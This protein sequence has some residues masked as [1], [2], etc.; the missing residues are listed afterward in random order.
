MA[1]SLLWGRY[2]NRS[3]KFL[4][5]FVREQNLLTVSG[6]T[7]KEPGS[8]ERC[9]RTRVCE[10][11][12]V[13]TAGM[14][15]RMWLLTSHSVSFTKICWRRF[16]FPSGL[17]I[18]TFCLSSCTVTLSFKSIHLW[19]FPICVP[20]AGVSKP[21]DIIQIIWVALEIQISRN[22]PEQSHQDLRERISLFSSSPH[23]VHGQ[24]G[25]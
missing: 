8:A 16:S 10:L 15:L 19:S 14:L 7:W 22:P 18:T 12:F 25:L 23:C 6:S 17:W 24:P 3:G 4:S 9:H 20:V 13:F 2:T 11:I 5:T 21:Y 1:W